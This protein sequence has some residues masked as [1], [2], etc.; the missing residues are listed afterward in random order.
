MSQAIENKGR[1]HSLI[2]KKYDALGSRLSGTVAPALATCHQPQRALREAK[3]LSFLTGQAYAASNSEATELA[4][5]E[6]NTW[7]RP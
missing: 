6:R 1:R 4:S 3:E 2:A 7:P 5:K